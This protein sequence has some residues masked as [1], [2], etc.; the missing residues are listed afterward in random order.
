[1]QATHNLCHKFGWKIPPLQPPVSGSQRLGKVERGQY[2]QT[3]LVFRGFTQVSCLKPLA[4]AQGLCFFQS[5]FKLI[6]SPS[7]ANKL[8]LNL[9]KQWTTDFKKCA[10]FEK[11]ILS[12]G[13][14]T[15]F[16]SNQFL[17]WRQGFI[18][19][20]LKNRES[21]TRIDRFKYKKITTKTKIYNWCASLI[22]TLWHFT[23]KIL[24]F[25]FYIY[26]LHLKKRK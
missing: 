17:F 7:V 5:C 16:L 8:K 15:I 23:F 6:S 12:W 24:H 4:N 21:T 10:I 3:F 25:I 11:S 26:I 13:E 1:M 2:C 9:K 14:K 20:I 19:L 22:Y 18:S